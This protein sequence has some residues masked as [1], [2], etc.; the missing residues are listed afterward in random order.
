MNCQTFAIFSKQ[1]FAL[2]LKMTLKGIQK[3]SK[4]F[5]RPND[6]IKRPLLFQT[7]NNILTISSD[8]DNSPENR[9]R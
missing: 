5:I 2:K 7:D 4:T 3:V 8:V 1:F 6:N 9:Y